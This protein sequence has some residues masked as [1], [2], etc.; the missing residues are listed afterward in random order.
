MGPSSIGVPAHPLALLSS[1]TGVSTRTDLLAEAFCGIEFGDSVD[2]ATEKLEG[3]CDELERREVTPASLPLARDTQTHLIAHGAASAG[4][5][6]VAFTFADDAL[7]LVEARGGAVD[8]LLLAFEGQESFTISGYEAWASAGVVAN[9]EAD[10]VW[11][12]SAE[13]L[14]PNLFLWANP[15]LPSVAVREAPYDASAARPRLLTFG[16]SREA[17]MPRI[18]AASSF[19]S[20]D[21]IAAPWLPTQPA[22]QVQVNAFGVVYAGFPRKIEAVFGDDRLQLAWILTGKQ[23]EARVRR[24]LVEAF[25]PPVFVSKTWEAFDDWRVALRKDKPE[26]LM[27]AD[28]LVPLYRPQIEASADGAAP[29][30][31]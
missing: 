3:S 11:I 13:A 29:R 24:S 7:V 4:V 26:V 27:L 10:A 25:G 15:D 16:E 14:H 19:W 9:A 23:E 17:L 5:D 2:E 8:G 30:S 6:E 28:E 21:E 1:S 31:D 20:V 12:L 18:E 22:R